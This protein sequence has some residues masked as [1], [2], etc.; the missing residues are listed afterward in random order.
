M[1]LLRS[2]LWAT[3]LY[4]AKGTS[5]PWQGGLRQGSSAKDAADQ[6]RDLAG[7]VP[8]PPP[9]DEEDEEE[10]WDA[11]VNYAF[12]GAMTDSRNRVFECLGGI[13]QPC[14]PIP[15]WQADLESVGLEAAGVAQQLEWAAEYL[16][17]VDPAKDLFMLW[18]G[19]NDYLGPYPG[20]TPGNDPPEYGEPFPPDFPPEF[21]P[22]TAAYTTQ[23]MATALDRAYYDMDARIFLMGNFLNPCWTVVCTK[24]E[25]VDAFIPG[26]STGL[27]LYADVW[28]DQFNR[29]MQTV[30]DD[31][32]A[33]H[34]DAT[35]MFMDFYSKFDELL[36]S[37]DFIA[38]LTCKDAIALGVADIDGP[39]M[40]G[41]YNCSDFAWTNDFHPTS[42]FWGRIV[43]ESLIPIIDE[44]LEPETDIRRIVV[45]G[46]SFTDKGTFQD[47]A[48]RANETWA[49]TWNGPP[50]NGEAAFDGYSLID[51][52]EQAMGL[53][54]SVPF[55]QRSTLDDAV[56]PPPKQ[57][58][59]PKYD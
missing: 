34:T 13:I 55:I 11:E 21:A 43:D 1:L 3:L 30:V 25:A 27:K 44:T 47:T 29:G 56:P 26:F 57:A 50:A 40:N 15:I 12:F 24:F 31:F 4:V 18:A 9:F 19:G 2:C 52:M 39:D 10:C 54:P 51:L 16:T 41:H 23:N 36:Q 58:C 53:E 38:N 48:R 8:T 7:E 46:D 45:I 42:T 35:I 6:Q 14:E 5:S 33:I 22:V 32:L 37:G 17:D 59:R 49:A 20:W 28:T